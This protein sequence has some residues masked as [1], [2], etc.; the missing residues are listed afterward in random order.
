MKLCNLLVRNDFFCWNCSTFSFNFFFNLGH[1]SA[2]SLK[3]YDPVASVEQRQERAIA[4]QTRF[5]PALNERGIVPPVN[6]SS[7]DQ[8]GQ[9]PGTIPADNVPP[10]NLQLENNTVEDNGN[11][12]A[13]QNQRSEN[14]SGIYDFFKH[15]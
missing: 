5:R 10:V 11:V 13:A 4:L 9:D 2:E 7:E 6:P 12:Q 1:K 3:N 8:A 14:A 15:V